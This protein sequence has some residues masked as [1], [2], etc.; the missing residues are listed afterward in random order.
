MD[1]TSEK[2]NRRRG[3]PDADQRQHRGAESH[4][5]QYCAAV[6]F[7]LTRVLQACAAAATS[8]Q[9]GEP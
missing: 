6:G 1:R 9:P 2:G 3:P 7:V 5:D 8:H 4:G